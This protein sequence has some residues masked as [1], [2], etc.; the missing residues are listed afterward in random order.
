MNEKKGRVYLVGAGPGDIGLLTVKGMKCLQ[1]A[2]AV[3]YD[4]HLN[5]QVLNYIKHDAEF[6]YAGKRGGHHTMTQDEINKVLV[7]KAKEGKVVCRLKG[8]DPFVFGRGGEEAEALAE[9]NID[10]EVV[11]GVSS[12]VAAPAY[13]GIPIT[14]RGYSSSFAVIP[15]YEDMTKEESAIDWS[16]LATGAGT[17]IFLMAVKNMDVLVKKLMENGRSPDTPV[18]VIRWGTRPDQKTITGTLRDIVDIVKEKDIKPP[19]VMVIGEVVKLRERL[20]WYEKKPMFGHRVLVT[21]EHAGGF[22]PLEDLGAEII[23]FPTIEIAPP[24][25][26]DELDS[27]INKIGAYNWIIFT[28]G[29]GVE[30]F[31]KRLMEK[32]KDIRDLKGIRICAIGT[33][34]AAEIQRYGIKVDLIPEE[35]NAEGLIEAFLKIQNSKLKTPSLKGI[36]ILLPRAEKA[37]EIFPEKVRESGGEIDVPAA[38]R[39]VKPEMHGKRLKRFLK[40]GRI[41]VATFTSASTFDNFMEIM[42]ADADELLRGVAIAVIGPV[43][44]RAVE[45]AGLKVEIMPETA[46]IKAMAEDII[47]WAAKRQA[48]V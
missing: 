11:P 23:E 20:M 32:D 45:K 42:G 18:A 35:F 17:L 8:G 25:N 22:E 29:K 28:S 37:R 31:L 43:T 16:K 26:Y 19:A 36:K 10:F 30:Y 27:A 13:A 4:F 21:R 7:E 1:R 40:E 24:E 48:A 46:T 9:N 15:G 12:A 2:D 33:K 41:S 3:V 34:T 39:A 5:A 47:K 6:I 38:Y 44:A 14:H